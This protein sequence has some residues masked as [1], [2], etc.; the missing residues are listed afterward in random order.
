MSGVAI[1]RLR[2]AM[3]EAGFGQSELARAAGCTPGAINQILQGNVRRSRFLPEIA[4][5]L[6][7]S[8]RWLNGQNVPDR[9][10][11]PSPPAAISPRSPPIM[12][13]VTLPAEAALAAAFQGVLLA[14]EGM[15][16]AELALELA[17][18]LPIVLR[19][20]AGS[21]VEPASDRADDPLAP[22]GPPADAPRE[23]RRA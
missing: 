18:R 8:L 19:M 14:S 10:S 3:Q 9:L 4:E 11:A 17:K 2:Q 15:D 20:S 22:D 5:A 6:G 7:V 13:P 12:L 16:V 21:I 1:D 23:R